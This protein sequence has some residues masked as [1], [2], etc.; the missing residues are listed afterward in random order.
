MLIKFQETK[1]EKS[2]LMESYN[3]VRFIN[4][5]KKSNT[6][7][8]EVNET[9]IVIIDFGN[10]PLQDFL[11]WIDNN[12]KKI[13]GLFLT[14][15][16]ADH[17][18][19][20]DA[21]K[22]KF[23]FPLY[24]SAQCEVN[25]RNPK[26]NYSRYIEEFE[27]FGVNSEAVVVQE[28]QVLQFDQLEIKVIE[29]PGHSPGSICLLTNNFVFTGDT[30]LNNVKSPLSFPS[31]N[32]KEYAHSIQKLKSIIKENKLIFPGHDES[33]LFNRDNL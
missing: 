8:I 31:S 10:Y 14:H 6:F 7:V 16:H 30:I 4:P 25:M 9:D 1:Q 24:C 17:C 19:G 27:T 18:Y 20:V 22:E 11:N 5:Y 3:V 13:V 28:N 32:K 12:N 23:N 21:L 15:E 26:Q 2:F 33:F 29:T